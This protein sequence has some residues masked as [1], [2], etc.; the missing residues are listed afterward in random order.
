[1]S[2]RARALLV[3]AALCLAIFIYDEVLRELLLPVVQIPPL[4]GGVRTLTLVLWAF[5]LLHAT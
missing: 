1:M 4:P 2:R 5:S 3:G